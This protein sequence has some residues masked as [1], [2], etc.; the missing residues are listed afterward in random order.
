MNPP[1]FISRTRA[2]S[3]KQ[4]FRAAVC[5]L[6]LA[7]TLSLLPS[8]IVGQT[9][10]APAFYR[11]CVHLLDPSSVNAPAPQID[12][13]PPPAYES[14][15]APADPLQV[16]A[17]TQRFYP[18]MLRQAGV[19]GTVFLRV[20]VPSTGTPAVVS[21]LRSSGAPPLDFAA[22]RVACSLE[23]SPARAQGAPAG[24]WIEM[25]FRF[26]P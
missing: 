26:D 6:S 9:P 20:F 8:E 10:S 18:P 1:P 2:A 12:T 16:S 21:P 5:L 25:P 13:V 22:M 7:I 15:P 19:G 11:L 17:E 23:F 14:L 24:A 3:G 4:C